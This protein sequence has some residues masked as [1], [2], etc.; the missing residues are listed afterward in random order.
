VQDLLV[1]AQLFQ[2]FAFGNRIVP[3]VPA[4]ALREGRFHRVPV[5]SGGTRDEHRL[6][7]GLFRDLAGQPVTPEQY[8]G[9]LAEAFGEHAG[10]VQARYP[11]SDYESPSVAWASV[12][13]D[14]MWARPTFEQ[15]RLLAEHVP[16]Y[17]YEFADEQAPMYLPFPE[18]LP[19]GA[20]HASEVPY[21]FIDEKFEAGST[22]EQ[23]S[24]SAQMIRY[25]A[26]FART[27]DPNGADL[28]EWQPFDPVPRVLSLA[29]GSDGLKPVDYAAEHA[30]DFWS[31]L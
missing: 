27:G 5:M 10:A 26:N 13:T 6:L 19:P 21:I 12:L 8:P 4:T 28:P 14:R 2:P 15:H 29:P 31:G 11:L 18:S 1:H 25:R 24:L 7:V 3:E 23:R 30:L 22:P 16:T 20:F 9:L 17:A